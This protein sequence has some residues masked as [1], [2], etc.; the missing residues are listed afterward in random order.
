MR[1]V[2]LCL[3]DCLTPHASAR[4]GLY[5]AVLYAARFGVSLCRKRCL[6]SIRAL[7][8]RF[9]LAMHLYIGRGIALC[10]TS[11]GWVWKRQTLGVRVACALAVGNMLHNRGFPQS[12]QGKGRVGR[13]KPMA[14]AVR[15]HFEQGLV[16]TALTCDSLYFIHVYLRFCGR[17]AQIEPKIFQCAMP[18]IKDR[19]GQRFAVEKSSCELLTMWTTLKIGSRSRGVV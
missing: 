2:R 1:A 19:A 9:H 15:A 17:L 5:M 4:G 14:N 10:D 12:E 11:W 18:S 6:Q 3:R 16:I 8:T 13:G 7:V